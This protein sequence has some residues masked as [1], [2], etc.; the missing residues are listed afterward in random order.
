[1]ITKARRLWF[2]MVPST[3]TRRQPIHRADHGTVHEPPTTRLG[4]R[5]NPVVLED[6]HDPEEPTV[7]IRESAWKPVSRVKAA[8]VVKPKTPPKALPA[9]K[10]ECSICAT[11]KTI[12][13]SFRL[14]G[15]SGVCAHFQDIC[16]LCIQ[17]M[18]KTKV[19]E[20]QLSQ[21]DLACPFPKCDHALDTT[22]LKKACTNK[23][24]I[25]QY[26]QALVKHHLSASPHYI[27]CLSSTCGAYFS[28]EDCHGKSRNKA[29][30]IS[31][32][33]IE[34]P[35]CDFEM[36][37]TCN[38]PWHA[39]TGCDKAK[40]KEDADSV[41]GIKAMGAKSCPKCGLNIDKNGGCD[42]M[43]CHTCKHNFCWECLLPYGDGT[44]HAQGC[45]HGRRDVAMD[46]G[47]WYVDCRVM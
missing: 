29:S 47:N 26:D 24:I 32:Q 15:N 20:R 19:A 37:F 35:H 2:E 34:C 31:K 23:I 45:S 38:R 3:R 9:G 25:A 1:M 11:S 8:A 14:T 41:A 39:Q 10:R 7:S 22:M 27:V 18:L 13:H 12:S 28:I 44:Q 21:P 6:T 16:G 42:H 46:P 40:R 30:R 5:A 43:T 36:C 33:R 4:T 17:K